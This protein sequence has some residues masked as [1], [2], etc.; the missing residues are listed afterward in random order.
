MATIDDLKTRLL[1]RFRAVPGVTDED[2]ATWVIESMIYHGYSDTSD[3][4]EIDTAKIL[5][6]AQGD[7]CFQI[8][9][10]VG[11]Y[12]QYTDGEEAVNKSMISDNYRKLARELRIE[13][14][15][16]IAEDRARFSTFKAPRRQDR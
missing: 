9:A 11:H 3:V 10:Q 15:R 4:P 1:A 2:V 8:A 13:H 7:G 6:Y 16:K 14:R 5:L 12:F